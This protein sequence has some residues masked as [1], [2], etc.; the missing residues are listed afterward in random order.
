MYTKYETIIPDVNLL[1]FNHYNINEKQLNWMKWFY[2]SEKN[3]T[4]NG[5]DDGMLRYKDIIQNIFDAKDTI[6]L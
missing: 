6:G 5:N 4:I 2:N 1:R 3:F